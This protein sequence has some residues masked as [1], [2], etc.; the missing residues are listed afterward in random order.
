MSKYTF[1]KTGTYTITLPDNYEVEI[2]KPV[3]DMSL[4]ELIEC[5]N[6]GADAMDAIRLKY[7]NKVERTCVGL[8]WHD[9]YE[10]TMRAR[11]RKKPQKTFEPYTIE[12]TGWSVGVLH[13]ADGKDEDIAIGC[14]T[15]NAKDLLAALKALAVS[16]EPEYPKAFN[17]SG[18]RLRAL[19]FEEKTT[20]K[21]MAVQL[22]ATMRGARYE[23]H[24]LPWADAEEL[25]KKLEQYL[26]GGK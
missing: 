21:S 8:D 24:V 13:R 6:R 17:L 1:P 11:F 26:E 7:P 23:R 5:A 15:F 18:D 4:D 25:M 12:S 19:I 20:T 3:E 14:K 16:Q 9:I 22:Y 2:K 10:K